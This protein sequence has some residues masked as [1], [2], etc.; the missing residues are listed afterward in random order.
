MKSRK[1]GVL[2]TVAAAAANLKDDT[3]D[4][5]VCLDNS[6]NPLTAVLPRIK[7]GSILGINYQASQAE[8]R[9]IHALGHNGDEVIVAS[10]RYRVIIDH[11]DATVESARRGTERRYATLAPATLSGNAAT[12]RSN[13]YTDLVTK[14]NNDYSNYGTGYLMNKI[15]AVGAAGI[16]SGMVAGDTIFQGATLAAATWTGKLAYI[17]PAWSAAAGQ[18]ICVYDETGT[19]AV[20]GEIKKGTGAGT[21]ITNVAGGD[22]S[23]VASQGLVFVDDA[24]YYRTPNELR[25]GKS[26]LWAQSFVTAVVA[27]TNQGAYSIGIGTDLLA[28]KAVF[29]LRKNDVLSGNADFTFDIDP[30]AGQTYELATIKV[31]ADSIEALS[32]GV[33]SREVELQLYMDETTGANV[34]ALKAALSAMS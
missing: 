11:L 34:T 24:G 16:T 4:Y 10:R 28:M 30:V 26:I 7:K 17:N 33:E 20:D 29:N 15:T 14:I 12:D 32:Q 27:I 1:I 5:V 6:A 18:I 23:K 19:F 2:N 25:P 13:V 21:A 22:H 9:R 31:K 3:T 8:V